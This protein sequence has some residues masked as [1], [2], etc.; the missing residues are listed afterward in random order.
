[1]LRSMYSGISG[2]KVNQT[3][4]DVIGNNISN[5]GTTS[6]KASRARFSDMLSQNVSDAMAPSNN[7][8]GVNASQ[9][10]LGVQLASIDSVMTQGMMQPTGR[11]LD[12][13]IDGDGFFM[14]SKGPAI[15]DGALEVNHRAGAHN[16]TAQSLSNSGSEIMY[17]RDGSFILD[18]QGNLLT[19]D[20]F[21]IMGYSLTNDDSSQQATG[22]S[23]N[24]VSTA[25]LDFRFGPGSQLNGFKVVL[26]AVGPGTVT[27]A[28]VNKAEK[29]IVVNGDFSSTGA[30]TTAQVESAISKGLSSA[31]ISQQV[32]VSGKPISFEGLGSLA[33][34]GGTDALAPKSVT[35]AGFN[36][37]LSEGSDLNG[38][39][40]EIG[41]ISSDPLSVNVESGR[42]KI[43]INADFLNKSF[44]A[45]DLQDELNNKLKAASITQEA[46]ITGTPATLGNI[47]GAS[48][49]SGKVDSPAGITYSNNSGTA[50]NVG[51]FTF[52]GQTNGELNDYTISIGESA[53]GTPLTVVV[54]NGNIIIN[55]DFNSNP[56]KFTN[57][58]LETK[59]NS[60]LK[61]NGLKTQLNVTGN[62]SS[63]DI[64]NK[65]KLSGGVTASSPKSLNIAGLNV[66]L[67]TGTLLNELQFEITDI[68]ESGLSVEY[69]PAAN[70]NAH[71]LVIKGD[72]TKKVAAKDLQDKINAALL[73]QY[74]VESP[75]VKVSGTSKPYTGLTSDNIDGGEVDK[76]PG[77][78]TV[79]GVEILLDAGAALNGYKFQIGTITAG[80]KTSASI[81]TKNKTIIINGDF[82]T[83]NAITSKNIQDALTRAL[84]DKGINQGIT[85]SNK[86]MELGG[87]ESEET[88]GGTPIE[89]MNGDGSI[90]FVDGTKNLKSYDGEL[91]TL[92]IP[93]KVKI[94][95]S[96]IELKVKTYTIDKNGVINGVLEDGRVAALGQ[97]A[98]ANFKNPEGLTKLGGNLY[99]SSVNS[100]DAIIK[101]GVGTLNDDNSKGYGDSLQG[102]LE[103]SNVDLA[104][105]FTDMIVSSRAFQA[106]GK[107]ITTGDEI[108]QDIIN[109]KR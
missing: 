51:G 1:M 98:M 86:P 8:G 15:Y 99:S 40:F 92:K 94:P 73:A 22:L 65:A 88:N 42:K 4:L 66:D 37:Q 75:K 12:V 5:V 19:G 10:G 36:I 68:N 14:V 56:A 25:G 82:V 63:V 74:P 21:R 13:A 91:K 55:G 71:K 59:L 108:L 45:S 18:E 38:Y 16:I 72:F 30:L 44:N 96:D 24:S 33:V 95:G 54:E 47:S 100:G 43:V 67:P 29:L 52:S 58:E 50:T 60:A 2:M 93:D 6:F 11:A 79:G 46:K 103:M 87:V 107:M 41:E 78:V 61:A 49:A 62:I 34:A 101:S 3:K 77:K 83:T 76:A 39:S 48:D 20:G 106:S 57:L 7:Q 17:S 31:G 26:G 81:D 27:S 9:V 35:I 104:E 70:G 102:M 53:I 85:V 23:P 105:Q 89:S 28:D 32:Y 90:N 97:I 69:E 84:E 109:L 80:T 64:S